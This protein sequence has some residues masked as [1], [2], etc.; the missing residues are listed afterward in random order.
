MQAYNKYGW[1]AGYAN[2]DFGADRAGVFV[3]GVLDAVR[4]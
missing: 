4:D 1:F 2:L 3:D